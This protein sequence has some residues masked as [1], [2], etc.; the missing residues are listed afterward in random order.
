MTVQLADVDTVLKGLEIISIIGS[1]ALLMY[2]LGRTT[3]RFEQV[4]TQQ[5]AE[6]GQLKIAI[7]KMGALAVVTARQDDRMNAMDQRRL[8]QGQ[9]LDEFQRLFFKMMNVTTAV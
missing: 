6:I 1:A 8:T 3:E 2:R 7:E 9:R 4:G 5:A